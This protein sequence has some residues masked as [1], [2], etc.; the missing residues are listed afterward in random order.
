MTMASSLPRPSEAPLRKANAGLLSAARGSKNAGGSFS[1][2]YS[3]AFTRVT[4]SLSLSHGYSSTY[5]NTIPQ[6]AWISDGFGRTM[7]TAWRRCPVVRRREGHTSVSTFVWRRVTQRATSTMPLPIVHAHMQCQ[8]FNVSVLSQNFALLCSCHHLCLA[9]STVLRH[10]RMSSTMT[11]QMPGR[12][13]DGNAFGALIM[14]LHHSTF[15]V[16][17][18]PTIAVANFALSS[19]G[20]PTFSREGSGPGDPHPG[21]QGP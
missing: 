14:P 11:M 8:L 5:P 19:K 2:R 6:M 17:T 12:D 1:S 15:A 7:E 16:H 18:S 13:A 10:W 20:A 3:A 9:P 21:R 4:V